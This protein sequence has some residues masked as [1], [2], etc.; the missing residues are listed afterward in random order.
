[1]GNKTPSKT[2]LI[3]ATPMTNAMEMYNWVLEKSNYHKYV[4]GE[5]PEK[6]GLDEKGLKLV[7]GLWKDI[8]MS[9]AEREEITKVSCQAILALST[10]IVMFVT[11]QQGSFEN[12]VSLLSLS[13]FSVWSKIDSV[14]KYDTR[15]PTSIKVHLLS[16]ETT[17]VSKRLWGE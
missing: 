4:V 5:L 3:K 9:E 10:E 12:L 1:M 15:M 7:N 17:L 6:L 16:L 14:L 11:N 2:P 13:W 8:C